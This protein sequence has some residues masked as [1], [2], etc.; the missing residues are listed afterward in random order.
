MAKQ[1]QDAMVEHELRVVRRLLALLL[2][3]GKMKRLQIQLLAAS[4]M[5]RSEIADLVG[6]TVGTV[7]VEMSN[8]RKRKSEESRGRR[9]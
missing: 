1:N 5:E 7:S 4:G 2:I 3:D 8:L 6:T 9:A